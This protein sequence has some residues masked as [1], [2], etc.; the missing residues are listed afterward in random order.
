MSTVQQKDQM[1]RRGSFSKDD[2]KKHIQPMRPRDN[3][4]GDFA[5]DRNKGPASNQKTIDRS[6]KTKSRM[7]RDRDPVI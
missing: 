6:T 3:I 7:R 1:K 2:L 4:S 5:G